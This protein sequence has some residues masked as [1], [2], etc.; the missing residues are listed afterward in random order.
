MMSSGES[1]EIPTLPT[2]DLWESQ[3]KPGDTFIKE[4]VRSNVEQTDT[5]DDSMAVP[6]EVSGSESKNLREDATMPAVYNERSRPYSSDFKKPNLSVDYTNS[7]SSIPTKSLDFGIK[8]L[9]I[10]STMPEVRKKEL[11][12]LSDSEKPNLP[13][14]ST[15]PAVHETEKPHLPVSEK[16]SLPKETTSSAV[17]EEGQPRLSDS[18]KPLPRADSKPA[19]RRDFDVQT[20]KPR[21]SS[22]HQHPKVPIPQQSDLMPKCHSNPEDEDF[23][24]GTLISKPDPNRLS[25]INETSFS[26]F[27]GKI[28]KYLDSWAFKVHNFYKA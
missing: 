24:S 15:M 13:K 4:R 3:Y 28:K 14:N 6:D 7:V 9:R 8:K 20:P 5:E 27:S 19:L 18:K 11:P 23:Q 1:M 12:D 25:K 21:A 22:S 16:P 17:H 10:Y 26:K 2:P